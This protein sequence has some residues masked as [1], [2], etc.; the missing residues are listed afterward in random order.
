LEQNHKLER[1][2][3]VYEE[4][5][6]RLPTSGEDMSG[7]DK[8]RAVGIAYKLGEM[9]G[10]M[11]GK[12]EKE[13]GYLAWAVEALLKSMKNDSERKP[14][15]ENVN[16]DSDSVIKALQLPEWASKIDIAAPFEAL[17]SFYA[18]NGRLEYVP[19]N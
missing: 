11:K 15:G 10:V 13:E 9:A 8:L 6:E 1:A 14:K 18:R 5:L 17:G 4:A 7:R 12:E 3:E 2:F 19:V 16:D